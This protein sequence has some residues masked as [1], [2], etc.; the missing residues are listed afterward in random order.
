MNN[1][2]KNKFRIGHFYRL[3]LRVLSYN[4]YF[5]SERNQNNLTNQN[6]ILENMVRNTVYTQKLN[7][8]L[9]KG[10]VLINEHREVLIYYNR[11][12]V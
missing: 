6:E 7:K 10:P 2:F 1:L 9:A 11:L 3:R 8:Y 5:F 12:S 4:K